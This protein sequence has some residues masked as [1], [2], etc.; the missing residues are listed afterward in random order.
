MCGQAIYRISQD[1]EDNNIRTN[2][3]PKNLTQAV[4]AVQIGVDFCFS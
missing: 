1:Y 3:F 4:R 2:D